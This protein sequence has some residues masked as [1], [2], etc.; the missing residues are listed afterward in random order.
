MDKKK[1]R[2][3]TFRLASQLENETLG[4]SFINFKSNTRRFPDFHLNKKR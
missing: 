2:M 1:T 4:L 3:I